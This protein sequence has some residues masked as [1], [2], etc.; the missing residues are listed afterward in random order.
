MGTSISSSSSTSPTL[1][2]KVN[3]AVYGK[4][5][6]RVCQ[7]ESF[8]VEYLT[9]NIAIAISIGK[10]L[11]W[12]DSQTHYL[13]FAFAD[14]DWCLSISPSGMIQKNLGNIELGSACWSNVCNNSTRSTYY[15]KDGTS[16]ADCQDVNIE[17]I[18]SRPT[19]G[20]ITPMD[21]LVLRT[22]SPNGYF[23]NII[24]IYEDV[25]TEPILPNT[26]KVPERPVLVFSLNQEPVFCINPVSLSHRFFEDPKSQSENPLNFTFTSTS[27]PS[28]LDVLYSKENIPRAN[29]KMGIQVVNE[30]VG[31]V[32]E[33]KLRSETDVIKIIDFCVTA[34]MISPHWALSCVLDPSEMSPC[35]LWFAYT[36]DG[37]D[38]WEN[39]ATKI[40]TFFAAGLSLQNGDIYE[41]FNGDPIIQTTI[42]KNVSCPVGYFVTRFCGSG[43][44]ADCANNGMQTTASVKNGTSPL[45]YGQIQC[46]RVDRVLPEDESKEAAALIKDSS[47][48]MPDRKWYTIDQWYRMCPDKQFLTGACVSGKNSDCD[49]HRGKIECSSYSDILYPSGL[50]YE[51][52]RPF[53][54]RSLQSGAA[55]VGLCN[56]GENVTDC[57]GIFSQLGYGFVEVGKTR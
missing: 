29:A 41:G 26:E 16:N 6:R 20:E 17:D 35:T 8:S 42:G 53:A 46:S 56:G 37:S 12:E 2:T 21:R 24:E 15:K 27:N 47:Y 19:R 57:G 9:S 23:V 25:N 55:A 51:P 5:F 31:M 13:K 50:G 11:I 32:P 30:N 34:C 1:T 36:N 54:T 22:M 14:H 39:A 40:P 28:Y 18:Q 48:L 3:E 4:R 45:I 52:G 10:W 7:G 33:Y 44:N 43:E 38:S 49:G